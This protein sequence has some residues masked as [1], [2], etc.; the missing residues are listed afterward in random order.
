MHSSTSV[1]ERMVSSNLCVSMNVSVA[2]SLSGHERFWTG[3]DSGLP[4]SEAA[5]RSWSVYDAA[6]ST[7]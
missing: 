2:A 7:L 4:A 1:V 6:S 3:L 5:S